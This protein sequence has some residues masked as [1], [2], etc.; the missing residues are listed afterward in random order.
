[1]VKSVKVLKVLG[2]TFAKPIIKTF[3]VLTKN[4]KGKFRYIF[5][6]G[7]QTVYYY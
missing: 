5:V 4:P 2:K 3:G 7:G 6:Q 1:M